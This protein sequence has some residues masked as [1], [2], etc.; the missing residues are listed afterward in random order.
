MYKIWIYLEKGRWLQGLEKALYLQGTY[1]GSK[2]CRR[3]YYEIRGIFEKME[4]FKND[5]IGIIFWK[6][7][8]SSTKS[9]SKLV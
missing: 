1:F 4:I 2:F 5:L 6:K 3:G 8:R 7:N 9:I